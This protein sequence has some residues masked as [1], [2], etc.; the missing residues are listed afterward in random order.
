M[1][2]AAIHINGDDDFNSKV[3]NSST[4][5]L[6]DFWAEWCGPCKALAPTLDDI[7]SEFTG[8]LVVAK[9]DVDSN[10][11]LAT[12]HGIR[13]IPTLML[14][15]NG[16]VQETTAGALPKAQIVE[17]LNSHGIEITK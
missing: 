14:Y 6:V 2:T 11:E 5:V 13:S 4:P 10:K 17:M 8:Q 15:K 1:S 16:E 9:I 12:A 7:A 3:K